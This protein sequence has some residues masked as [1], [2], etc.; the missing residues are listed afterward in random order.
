MSSPGPRNPPPASRLALFATGPVFADGRLQLANGA[1]VEVFPGPSSPLSL[2]ALNARQSQLPQVFDDMSAVIAE[3]C[4]S[5]AAQHGPTARETYQC[6]V[7][8]VQGAG[9]P[10]AQ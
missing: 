3:A 5:R 6:H 7:G 10:A 1:A 4:K 9:I 8:Y 2:I